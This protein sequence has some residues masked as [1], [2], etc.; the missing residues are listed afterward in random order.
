MGATVTPEAGAFLGVFDELVR[1][2]GSATFERIEA[3]P[4]S[5]TQG[6]PV[7]VTLWYA[8]GTSG[9]VRLNCRYGTEGADPSSLLAG[10]VANPSSQTS[11]A[12]GTIDQVSVEAVGGAYV[13][14]FRWTPG[15]TSSAANVGIGPFSDAGEDVIALG[16]QVETGRRT[17]FMP[18]GSRSA[19]A[20]TLLPGEGTYDILLTFDDDSTQGINGVAVTEAGWLVPVS[21]LNRPTVKTIA[22]TLTGP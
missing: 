16:A 4:F 8:E 11:N 6:V 21:S 7:F 5:V 18:D 17:S 3:R 12:A 13:A 9:Q 10:P 22:G 1:V 20:L 15:E 14:R 19:D 2:T